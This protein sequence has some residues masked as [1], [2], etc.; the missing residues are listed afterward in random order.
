M[1]RTIGQS[2]VRLPYGVTGGILAG[3]VT[4][5]APYRSGVPPM[6][7]SLPTHGL[8]S[9]AGIEGHDIVSMTDQMMRDMLA[10]PT[11]VRCKIP[12]RV[13]IDSGYFKS[14]GAHAINRALI[15][16]R[17]RIERRSAG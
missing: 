10:N 4:A 14:T 6:T 13:L 5:S 3:C 2:R 16:N 15:T 17:L 1:Y 12:P 9:G 11:L 7:V 8:L